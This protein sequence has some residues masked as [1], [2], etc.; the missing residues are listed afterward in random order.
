MDG[1]VLRLWDGYSGHFFSATFP[2]SSLSFDSNLCFLVKPFGDD[3]L[4][5]CTSRPTGTEA[6]PPCALLLRHGKE[7]K[8]R[9]DSKE[10][11]SCQGYQR[12]FRGHMWM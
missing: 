8:D 6:P 11:V 2:P 1:K 4:T 10:R 3:P 12:I 7:S 9:V 5:L